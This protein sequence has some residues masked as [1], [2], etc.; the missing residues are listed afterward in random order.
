MQRS[1]RIEAELEREA[2]LT[3]AAVGTQGRRVLT[4]AGRIV[5]QRP[6]LTA[7]VLAAPVATAAWML[8]S[9]ARC[10][11]SESPAGEKGGRSLFAPLRFV[12]RTLLAM[13]FS[14]ILTALLA[15]AETPTVVVVQADPRCE[16][17][18]GMDD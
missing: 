17:I 1:T 10:P 13:N 12:I 18:Q 16:R 2:A 11:A 4:R 5:Q 3:W 9:R 6:F 7:L 14:R 15:P 8:T